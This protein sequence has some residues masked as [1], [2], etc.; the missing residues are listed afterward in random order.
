MRV[1]VCMYVCVGACVS[2]CVSV[3][4]CMKA[5]DAGLF[6]WMGSINKRYVVQDMS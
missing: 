1:C 3:R 4:T 6:E 2:V 5:I